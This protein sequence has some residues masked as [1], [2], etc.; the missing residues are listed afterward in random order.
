MQKSIV[1]AFPAAPVSIAIVWIDMLPSD[2]ENAAR[3]SAGIFAKDSR[4]R[5]F[6]DPKQRVGKALAHGL[7]WSSCAWDIYLFYPKGAEWRAKP[8]VPATYVHQMGTHALDGHFHTGDDLV[9][10]L[11]TI[12]ASTVGAASAGP[13]SPGKPR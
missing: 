3:K 1:E 12:M 6:Y 11:H 8:P 2:S 9:Q 5:Q 4:L 13:K 10:Q 7:G